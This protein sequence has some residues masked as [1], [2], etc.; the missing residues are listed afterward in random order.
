MLS[1]KHENVLLLIVYVSVILMWSFMKFDGH[2]LWKDEW[3]AWF[4]ARDMSIGKLFSFLYY[5]GHPALWYLYLRIFTFLPDLT[6]IAPEY[7]IMGAHLLITAVYMYVLLLR[8][9]IP[10]Y[11]KL[12]A[13]FSY[14]LYFEYGMISRGYA[15]VI[16][17]VFLIATEI[18]KD[19]SIDK[20]LGILFFLL[21]QTEVFGVFMAVSSG[22]FLLLKK[23]YKV[24]MP[25]PRFMKYLITGLSVFV[26]SV[27]PRTSGHVASTQPNAPGWFDQ[28]MNSFQ[29][30]LSNTFMIGS[31]PDTGA[32][33]WSAFG[34]L[35]SLAVFGMCWIIFR[36]N[37][38]I[39]ITGGFFIAMMI[40]FGT[41]FF[42]GGVRQWGM[43][44]VFFIILLEW[45]SHSTKHDL[46][47]KIFIFVFFIFSLIHGSRAVHAHFS[48]PFTNAKDAGIFIKESVPEKVPVVGINKFE[49]TPV[50]GYAGRAFYEL[51][52]GVPFTYFRWV[53]KIYLPSELELH[54]FTQFKKVGGIVIISPKLLDKERFPNAQL[55][56]SFDNENY[57][58]ENYYLYSLPLKLVH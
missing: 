31:T 46:L 52:D 3:Q 30:N 45:F 11:F 1:K 41:L 28:L 43:S 16:A 2:E 13:V 35:L 27:F 36:K 26:I 54:L 51:P 40:A 39:L 29:G 18:K 17:L 24:G 12:P 32:Y 38:H 33:G 47:S 4:V 25:L 57:K 9:N 21:C 44:F 55:W 10:W 8:F 53:D 37:K 5:E 34:I 20:R 42:S 15:L 49:I 22:L 7:I 6:G 58:R 14:F 23:G 56:K 19:H 50:I 48:I